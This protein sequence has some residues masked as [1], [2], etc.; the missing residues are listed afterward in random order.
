GAGYVREIAHR[1]QH[2]MSDCAQGAI[3]VGGF[4]ILVLGCWPGGGADY[5]GGRAARRT[6]APEAWA[7]YSATM[8]IPDKDI[9][10]LTPPTMNRMESIYLPEVFKGF[11]TT[12]RHMFTSF[13]KGKTNRTM[14]Y[15]E[16]RKEQRKPEDG[17]METRNFRGV[18]RLNRDERG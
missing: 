3:L 6:G 17:G 4:S 2:R 10:S 1:W 14:E 7:V 16:E 13:G 9:L 11:G 8:A 5:T 18:H 12:L 15:P